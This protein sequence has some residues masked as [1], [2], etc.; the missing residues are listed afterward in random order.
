[1]SEALNIKDVRDFDEG[2]I[3]LK[4]NIIIVNR[5]FNDLWESL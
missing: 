5:N 4:E 1:M 2:I 3:R